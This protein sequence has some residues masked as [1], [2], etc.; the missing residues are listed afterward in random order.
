MGRHDSQRVPLRRVVLE[1][2]D[3][4]AVGPV[5]A[6]VLVV[7]VLAPPVEDDQQEGPPAGDHRVRLQFPLL[8]NPHGRRGTAQGRRGVERALKRRIRESSGKQGGFPNQ[9]RRRSELGQS[10]VTAPSDVPHKAASFFP[11]AQRT[12][13]AL[14]QQDQKNE[15][16]SVF[17]LLCCSVPRSWCMKNPGHWFLPR[18]LP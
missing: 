11:A 1:A 16:S 18:A 10:Q 2:L 12:I 9:R 14:S 7:L 3:G 15:G 6:V 5:D 17:A 8:R 4:R 13:T